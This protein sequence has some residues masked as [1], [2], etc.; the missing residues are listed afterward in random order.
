MCV[1]IYMYM[2]VYLYDAVGR[3]VPR[4]CWVRQIILIDGQIDR[5]R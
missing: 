2:C 3:N 5:Y 1:C 4:L